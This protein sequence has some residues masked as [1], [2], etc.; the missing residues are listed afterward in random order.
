MNLCLLQ[1]IWPDLGDWKNADT[2]TSI[3]IIS[4]QTIWPDLGDWNVALATCGFE[5]TF[6][7]KSYD[8]I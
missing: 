8:P 3:S 6:N 1:T 4:L 7:Y 2:A 5:N